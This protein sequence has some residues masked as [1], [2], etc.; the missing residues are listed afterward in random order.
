MQK[1]INSLKGYKTYAVSVATLVYAVTGYV[2][3]NMTLT[4]LIGFLLFGAG[5]ATLRGAIAKVEVYLPSLFDGVTMLQTMADKIKD[6]ETLINAA[7]PAD[8][9][10]PVAPT[11][12][13]SPTV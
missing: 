3:G 7:K 1:F 11:P 2:S 4:Q 8:S 12:G 5:A 10:Q 9:T 13:Q 6:V